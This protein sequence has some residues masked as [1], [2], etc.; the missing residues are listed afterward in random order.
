MVA[1]E[2]KHTAQVTIALENVPVMG[3]K[4]LGTEMFHEG[5]FGSLNCWSGHIIVA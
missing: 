2:E 4:L 3:S 5:S 1:A